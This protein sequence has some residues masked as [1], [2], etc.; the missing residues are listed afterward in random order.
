MK[1]S[2]WLISAVALA[3]VLAAGCGGKGQTGQLDFSEWNKVT[4]PLPPPASHVVNVNK[5]F[6]H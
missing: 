3:A 2:S 5:L 4:I 6:G 1:R